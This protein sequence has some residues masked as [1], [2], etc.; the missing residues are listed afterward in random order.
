[1]KVVLTGE[2]NRQISIPS[3]APSGDA[4]TTAVPSDEGSVAIPS[5]LARVKMPGR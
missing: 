4:T 1:V 5:V 3:S 2:G